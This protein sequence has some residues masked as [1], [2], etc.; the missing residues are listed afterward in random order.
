MLSQWVLAAIHL[1]AFA[2]AFWAALTRGTAFRKL[3]A[4]T[5]EVKCVLLADN[6]WGFQL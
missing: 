5:G 2:L 3:S 4:G 6:L 1:F